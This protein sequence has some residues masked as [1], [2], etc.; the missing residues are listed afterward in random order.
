MTMPRSTGRGSE[1][2]PGA[3]RPHVAARRPGGRPSARPVFRVLVHRQ[4][5]SIWNELP[6]RVGLAN[7]QPFLEHLAVTPGQPPKVGTSNLIKGKH[8]APRWA[9]SSQ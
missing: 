2:A 8:A 9:G 1:P 6:G 5:L 3:Y 7:A 4:Y